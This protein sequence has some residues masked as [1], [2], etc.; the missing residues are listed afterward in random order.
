MADENRTTTY[1][2]CQKTQKEEAS[3][4]SDSFFCI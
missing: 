1:K 4:E 2:S 3:Y